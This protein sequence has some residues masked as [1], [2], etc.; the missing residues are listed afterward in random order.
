MNLFCHAGSVSFPVT[1]GLQ[2]E[3]RT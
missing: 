3:N 2:C 1:R